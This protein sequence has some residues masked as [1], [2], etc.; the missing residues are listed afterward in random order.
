MAA[1][2][3]TMRS[4]TISDQNLSNI[5]GAFVLLLCS[6]SEAF[7]GPVLERIQAKKT[8]VI[9]HRESSIPF[10]YTNEGK[11]IGY[12]LDLCAPIV[13]AV[14][15]HLKLQSI[16]RQYV[17]IT[18][19]NRVELVANGDVDLECGSTSN[20][21]E[22]REKVAFAIPHFITGARYLVR[23][24]SGIGSLRDL[25]KKKV[26]SVVGTA[27]LRALKI[28]NSQQLL[29]IDIVEAPDLDRATSMVEGRI[30]DAF[31]MDDIL[32]YGQVWKSSQPAQLSVV[33]KYLT[34]D[35]LAIMMPKNDPDFARI[36]NDELRQLIRSGEAQRLYA[37]WFLEPIPPRG[38][39]MNI[40]M[41]YYLKDFWKYPTDQITN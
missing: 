32:L 17:Q 23:S 12:A 4:A 15:S 31:V 22:R 29:D 36:V 9:G 26:T 8:I 37:K 27:P 3:G 5:I 38:V 20:T 1:M 24:D 13:E 21:A 11:P 10:S 41:N 25:A 2:K 39:S 28:A 6:L 34:I 33:G 35:P 40:P 30:A 7:A 19:S 14:R 16:Q 18:P